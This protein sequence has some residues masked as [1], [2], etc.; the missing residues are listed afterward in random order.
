MRRL[1]GRQSGLRCVWAI[2]GVALLLAARPALADMPVLEWSATYS[3][4]GLAEGRGVAVDDGGAYLTGRTWPDGGYWNIFLLKYDL[5]GNSVWDR[6]WGVPG[7]YVYGHKV[8]LLGNE[9]HVAGGRDEAVTLKYDSDGVLD[10]SQGEGLYDGV[11]ITGWWTLYTGSGYVGYDCAQDLALDE[12]GNLHVVGTTEH[13]WCNTWTYVEKYD[14][15]G[16]V[17]WH[18]DYGTYGVNCGA[19]HYGL[20]LSGGHLYSVGWYAETSTNWDA[21]ALKYGTDGAAVYA[22][23][24]GSAESNEGCMDVAVDGSNIYGTGYT[25]TDDPSER[26][27]L[28]LKLHDDGDS[29]SF[30]DSTVFVGPGNDIGQ[31]IVVGGG[32]IYVVGSTDVGGHTDALLLAYDTDLNLLWEHSWGGAGDDCAYDV[33]VHD[34]V[35]YVTGIVDNEAFVNAYTL[36]PASYDVCW[37]GSGDYTTIQAAIDAAT[38]GD[39]VVICDGTYTGPG[40]KDLDFGGRAITVRSEN[41]PDNCIIDCEGA[42]RGFYF[43]SGED[44]SAVVDGFTITN[45][46]IGGYERGGAILCNGSSPTIKM[47]AVRGNTAYHGGGFGCEGGGNPTVLNCILSDN[48][49]NSSGGGL[50]TTDNSDVTLVNCVFSGNSS[51]AHGGGLCFQGSGGSLLVN[52]IINGNSCTG[53]PGDNFLGGGV[54]LTNGSAV[55]LVNSTVSHNTSTGSG[56]GICINISG[57]CATVTNCVLWGNADSAGTDESAQIHVRAGGAAAVDYSCVQGWTGTLGGDGNIDADPVFA[58]PDGPDNDPDTCDDNDYRLS[59][60]SPCIDAG[61]TTAVPAGL[62]VD[63]DGNGR[64]VDWPGT[65]DTGIPAPIVP[66]TV[67][68]GAYEF[69]SP[70]GD[71]N[72]DGL[73]NAFDIDPFVLILVGD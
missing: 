58:D 48:H 72:G 60:A 33:A 31:G 42:G 8:A 73:V 2:V 61:D 69:D 32:R 30:V 1:A 41:G 52:C 27:L 39:T 15:A 66:V 54:F 20:Q 67:D 64:V 14:Q 71:I 25:W 26:D 57:D 5:A 38:D 19:Q 55:T 46:G 35:I 18:Q 6:T 24:F 16:A 34:G 29:A 4:L 7:K 36:G 68:M 56:G 13:G 10:M 49:G 40:N 22:E 12:A 44:S 43:H 47:C 59:F 23:L 63:L 65:D 28:V 62:F 11:L 50:H 53:D 45:G 51:E 9:V 3:G 21:A 17:Q 70:L 37:D